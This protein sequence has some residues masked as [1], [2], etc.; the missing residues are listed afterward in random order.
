MVIMVMDGH[1]GH[2]GT[3]GYFGVYAKISE[4]SQS[5]FALFEFLSRFQFVFDIH[6]R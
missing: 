1:H 4:I 3:H 5:W 6:V 2:H